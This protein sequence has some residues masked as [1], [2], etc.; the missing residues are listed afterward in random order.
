MTDIYPFSCK[1]ATRMRAVT[2]KILQLIA[3]PLLYW[4]PMR[5]PSARGWCSA[6]VPSSCAGPRPREARRV[7]A[8][9]AGRRN[10]KSGTQPPISHNEPGRVSTINKTLSPPPCSRVTWRRILYPGTTKSYSVRPGRHGQDAS[11]VGL[12]ACKLG[13]KVKIYTVA[14]P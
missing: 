12:H 8:L 13:M 7:P 3:P 9:R 6:S 5:L 14:E 11:V 10:G 4:A 1:V 2:F